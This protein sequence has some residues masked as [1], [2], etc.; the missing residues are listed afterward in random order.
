VSAFENARRE[1][2]E[3]G[4]TRIAGVLDAARRERVAGLIEHLFAEEGDRAGAEFRQEVK[5]ESNYLD[6]V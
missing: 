4:F 5:R 1:L 6:R 2:D 3:R